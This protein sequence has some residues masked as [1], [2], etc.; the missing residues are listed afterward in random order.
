MREISPDC[1]YTLVEVTGCG[2]FAEAAR[3]LHL[4]APTVSLRIAELEDRMG[5]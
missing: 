1:L 2:P 5:V 4:A 3:A